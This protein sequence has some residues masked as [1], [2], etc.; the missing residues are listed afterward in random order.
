MCF[1]GSIH[2]FYAAMIVLC[3][4]NIVTIIRLQIKKKDEKEFYNYN[5][6]LDSVGRLLRSMFRD[7]NINPPYP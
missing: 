7:D 5:R 6:C 4:C 3:F 1:Y 2:I